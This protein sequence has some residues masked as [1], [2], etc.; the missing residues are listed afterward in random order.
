[1]LSFVLGKHKQ[2]LKHTKNYIQTKF[3]EGYTG[4]QTGYYHQSVALSLQKDKKTFTLYPF[5]KSNLNND[6]IL[7]FK[8]F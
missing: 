8:N 1:M 5:Y 2:T 4:N 6:H 3:L 7:L